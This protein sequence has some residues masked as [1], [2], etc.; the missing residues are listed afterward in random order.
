[1]PTC[2]APH[3]RVPIAWGYLHLNAAPPRPLLQGMLAAGDQHLFADVPGGAHLLEQI[4]TGVGL[5]DPMSHLRQF[6]ATAGQQPTSSA[7]EWGD[8]GGG[9]G[10]GEE[11][12]PCMLG[13]AWNFRLVCRCRASEAQL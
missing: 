11:G 8:E 2:I 3:F 12:E 4:H 1:M 13:G 10:G 9:G 6:E 7:G 5:I